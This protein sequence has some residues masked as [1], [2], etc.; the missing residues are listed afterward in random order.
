MRLKFIVCKVL[1]REAYFCAARSKNVV[2]I[3]LMPQGLHNEPDKLR[4]QVQKE[5]EIIEDPH[6]RPYDALLLGYG[7]CSNGIDRVV[8][9]ATTIVPRA[10]DCVTIL[11]GSKDR[12]KEYFDSHRGTYW[13]SDGWIEQSLQPSKERVEK[14][15]KEYTE[16]YGQENAQ[17]LME[18]EQG[19]LK[20]Y[21]WAT[22]VDWGLAGSDEQKKFTQECAQFLNWKYDE[23]K[24]DSALLQRMLDG[25]WPDADF[26]KVLAGQKI[27]ADVTSEGIVRA[28]DDPQ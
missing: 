16:K 15:L 22:Y 13:Y 7:L 14:L 21:G 8:A 27:C 26:L 25:D 1:Q 24:G 9:R 10:H 6:G 19:W 4:E 28:S 2:D 23:L 18:M 20:E 12:Y 3:V 11:L 17:Y 5:M